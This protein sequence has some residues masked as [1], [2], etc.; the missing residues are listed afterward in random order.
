MGLGNYAS[1]AAVNA[2]QKKQEMNRLLKGRTP[3]Q[4]KVIKYFYQ[5]GGCLSSKLSDEQY[6]SMLQAKLSSTNF[7]LRA[8]DKLGLDES[9]VNEIEPVAFDNY[10]YDSNDAL[11]L[12]GKDGV[13]RSSKYQISW[14]FFSSD[15]VYVYQYTFNM[16]TDGKNEVTEEYFYKDVTNFSSSTDSVEKE[17]PDKVSCS[18]NITYTRSNVEYNRFALVVPGEKFYCSMKRTDYTEAAIRGMKAK[19]REKKL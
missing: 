9:Q 16:A 1:N 3:E 13:W 14:L 8:L 18:G 2:A 11:V 17:T 7:K 15:Q 4:Q 5:S 19:L 10:D 6:D 12:R